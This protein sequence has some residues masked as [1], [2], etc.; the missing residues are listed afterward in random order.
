MWG[1]LW[2][3][4]I[5]F[6][7]W[8]HIH[9][10]TNGKQKREKSCSSN[11][12]H[13]LRDI[14]YQLD[15]SEPCRTINDRGKFACVLGQRRKGRGNSREQKGGGNFTLPVFTRCSLFP[16]SR[17]IGVS[18]VCLLIPD[19]GELDLESTVEKGSNAYDCSMIFWILF[20]LSESFCSCFLLRF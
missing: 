2:H 6:Y 13:T 4:A 9:S 10:R 17:P 1:H 19:P 8:S 18:S 15:K 20:L 3:F 14:L 12:A 7:D 16:R 5:I 11:W